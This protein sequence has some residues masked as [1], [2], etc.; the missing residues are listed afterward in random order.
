MAR[1]EN[2]IVGLRFKTPKPGEAKTIFGKNIVSG[3]IGIFLTI[4]VVVFIIQFLLGGLA[5]IMSEGDENKVKGARDK[6]QN[7]LIG[8]VIIFS[9]F[10]IIKLIGYVFGITELESLGIP[11]IPL[12]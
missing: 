6:I 1:I 10:A 12:I 4:G 11:L 5:W 2:P 9:I 8:L 3:V 7:A